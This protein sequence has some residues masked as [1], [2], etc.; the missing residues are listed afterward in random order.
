[1]GKLEHEQTNVLSERLASREETGR[2]QI[3]VEEILVGLAGAKPETG[4]VGELLHRDLVGD[5]EGEEEI[6]RHLGDHSFEVTVVGEFVVRSINADS[7]KDLG[8]LGQAIPFETRL[9]EL[10]PPDIA[11][12]IV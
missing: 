10:C 5:F 8:I 9:S 11:G 3:G 12:F 1:M 7:L 4:K 2:E 6:A